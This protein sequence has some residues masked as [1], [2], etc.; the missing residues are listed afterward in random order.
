MKYEQHDDGNRQ[1]ILD[2]VEW[3]GLHKMENY[4]AL[5]RV[6]FDN[7][8]L[9]TCNQ[10]PIT[11]NRIQFSEPIRSRQYDGLL[12]EYGGY[13]SNVENGK[14]ILTN[15]ILAYRELMGSEGDNFM[16]QMCIFKEMTSSF[17]TWRGIEAAIT[18]I[19]AD[20]TQTVVGH[21]EVAATIQTPGR[22]MPLYLDEFSHPYIHQKVE[23]FYAAKM[24]QTELTTPLPTDNASADLIRSL[25]A[26]YPGRFLVIDFWGIGCGPCRAAIQNSKN[27]RAEVA[28]RN[29]MKLVF[30]AGERIPSG[31]DA[32]HK[33][34]ADEETVCVSNADFALLQ[35]LFRF[36]GIPHYETITP[37][38]RRVRDDLRISGLYNM[39]NELNRLKEKIK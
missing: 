29:D 22:M 20:T 6:D 1:V 21:E 28:K 2:S 23:A 32:Y 14:K 30:I 37:D 31:S 24:S 4:Q 12:D 13:E 15:G 35:E 19:L 3:E 10:Y 33:Y 17:N 11:I 9:L 26:K 18:K 34:V 36:N 39:N 7:P 16:A 8:L 25:C 38:C 27:Q 5:H